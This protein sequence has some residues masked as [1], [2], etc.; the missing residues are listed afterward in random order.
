M[1]ARRELRFDSLSEAV[2][3]A[4]TLL[5]KGYDK[6]G[7]WTLSQVCDHLTDWLTFPLDGFPKA[8]LPI[9]AM[10]WMMKVTIGKR[11]LQEYLKNRSFPAGK[12]T[13]PQSIHPPGDD[14]AAVVKYKAAA[15]RFMEHSGPYLP[16]PL[17]GAYS[18]EDAAR[19]QCVHA[20]HHLSFLVP[21]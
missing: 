5:A 21:K 16:S 9:A 20:A 2:R 12:P 6:A 14:A 19:L 13:M 17:F 1:A 7:N 10:L 18:N 15:K 3:D 8:P 4:E 11:K